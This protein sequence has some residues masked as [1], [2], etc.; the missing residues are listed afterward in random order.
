MRKLYEVRAA[1]TLVR[2]T[3]WCVARSNLPPQVTRLSW[4][5]IVSS[6]ANIAAAASEAATVATD[7]TWKCFVWPFAR[8]TV[9]RSRSEEHTSELQSPDHLVCRLLLEK[10]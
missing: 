3:Y 9:N 7:L 8:S 6:R 10:K 5:T 1:T 4:L 2:L